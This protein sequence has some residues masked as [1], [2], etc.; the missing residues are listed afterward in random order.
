M[1][2]LWG[3]L[4]CA[5][6]GYALIRQE[7]D[8]ADVLLNAGEAAVAL[9]MKLLATMALWGGLL[10]ILSHTGDVKRIGRGLRR[11]LDPLFGGVDDDECW[12]AISMNLSANLLG[13]GNAAT[14]SG[15]RAAQLLG[16][17]GK[18]GIQAL[19]MLLTLNNAGVQLIPATILTLRRAAGSADPA[20]IWLPSLA[21]AG[22]SVIVGAATLLLLYRRRGK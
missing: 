13:L 4:L 12:E 7:G 19:A 8:A 20:G 17:K 2:K 21:A 9:T 18:S 11:V 6:I 22:A 1:Q 3:W 14:P 10:E 5:A 16:S 15:I